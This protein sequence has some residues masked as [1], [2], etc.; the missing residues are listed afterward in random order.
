M[1]AE[2]FTNCSASRQMIDKATR[3]GVSTAFHRVQEKK[4]CPF[5]TGG[6]CCRI[7][8]MGPCRVK[9][10]GRDAGVCGATAE[11][12]AA[13]NF[14]RMIAA[15]AAAHSDHAREVALVFLA[16]V[17]GEAPG[18][19]IRDEEKLWAVAQDLGLDPAGK[20]TS[21][22]AEEV[23]L[24]VLAEF[25]QQEGELSFIRRAPAKR[26]EV[27]QKLN[28]VPRGIDREI[29]EMMHR[30]HMGVDQEYVHL[31]LHG[32]RASLADGWGGSMIATELQDII[33]GT[34]VPIRAKV[35][36]GVLRSDQV[37]IIVHGHE[38][39]LPELILLAI[40]DEEL[41]AQAR[42]VGATGINVAGICCTANEIL[43]RKGV[44]VAGSVLQQELALATGAVEAMAVDV[45]CIMQGLGQVARCYHTELFTTSSRA[46][47]PGVTHLEFDPQRGLEVAREIVQRAIKRFPQ[48]RKVEIP[49]EEMDLVAGFS[50][51]TIKYILGGRFRAS[52]RPLNDNVVNGRIRGVAAVVGCSNPRVRFGDLHTTL[53]RELIA[54][55]VLVLVTGCA[56]INCAKEGLLVPEAAE[57]AGSG[58]REVCEAVGMPPVLH[59][60]SC[61]DNSRLLIA[62]TEMV[63][64][65]GLGEDISELPLCGCAPEWMSE[66][67]IAIG[68]YFVTSGVTVGFGVAFPTSG[69]SK[70]S[71]FV[72][73][74]MEEY[75]GAHWFY[76]PDPVAMA[77]VIIEHIDAKRKALGIDVA[78]ERVLYDMEMRRKL[79][80]V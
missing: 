71:D 47:L 28:I 65:G 45:Q 49:A 11:T 70:L 62:A 19:E 48:R 60:G 36:L 32:M 55:D 41:Q 77:R 46:R 40:K 25:G 30:T 53:V 4:P 7:C 44:P 66:K 67:A 69:S 57:I 14:G 24:R 76:E 3:E 8:Y 9:D 1:K 56:A 33:F 61:V 79:E 27:W 16:A 23:A 52:Y 31:M 29:V 75:V 6:T 38:P 50:H 78:R 26:Q 74:G 64:E 51:E 13:R 68:Q 80:V 21:L 72:F 10:D 37:N 18:F 43:M 59:C 54:N 5:G 12:I 73:G 35:N 63:K 22:L 39:L 2:A 58:L 34:P 20:S 42:A 15:G 17:R